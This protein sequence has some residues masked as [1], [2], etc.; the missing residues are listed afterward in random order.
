MSLLTSADLAHMRAMQLAALPDTCT[1]QRPT[2]TTTPTGGT[3]TTY[4]AVATRVPF[5]LSS[6]FMSMRAAEGVTAE[7]VS[8]TAT[9]IAT[10]ETGTDVRPADRIVF[11]A[12]TLEVTGYATGSWETA[13]RVTVTEVS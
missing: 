13:K 5:R 7:R 2:V 12:R 11:G 1:I 8:Q 4:G 3:T 6:P 10:F 9:F